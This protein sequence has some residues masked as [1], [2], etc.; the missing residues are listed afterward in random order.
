ML[1]LAVLAFS[2]LFV[3]NAWVS[4]DAKIT[5][6]SVEQ[7]HAGQ[8]PRWNPHERVQAF[9]HPLWF[10]LL[11]AARSLSAESFLNAVVLSWALGLTAFLFSLRLFRDPW[12]WLL[13]WALLLS[14]RAF[15]D[16]SSSG[17]E[18]PLVFAL[19]TC[20]LVLFAD[21]MVVFE[22][23]A[24]AGIL[25]A[26]ATVS[27]LL[28]CRHD[29]ALLVGPPFLAFL[30]PR[31]RAA[32]RRAIATVAIGALPFVA[33]TLF[34]TVYYGFP[35]PNT[36]YAKL[37]TGIPDSDLWRQGIA[38]VVNLARWDPLTLVM[39]V[40]AIIV[41]LRERSPGVWWGL[42]MLAYTG[43]I[44]RIGGD[45]M[46]G[47]FFTPVL[48]V[49]AFTLAA[50]FPLARYGGV[51]AAS[52]LLYTLVL[53]GSP[54]KVGPDY[55]AAYDYN[56]PV[57]AGITDEKG[58]YFKGS[59]LWGH[60]AGRDR[61]GPPIDE[62]VTVAGAVGATGLQAG[63]DHIV[64]DENA[65]CDPLLARLP[66]E[67][68]WRIGHFRRAVPRGYP[69]SLRAGRNLIVNP[70]VHSLY[71]DVR[72]VTQGPLWDADRWRAIARLNLRPPR[73]PCADPPC[74]ELALYVMPVSTYVPRFWR[75]TGSLDRVRADGPV[76]SVEGRVPFGDL[77]R[78][79]LHVAVPVAAQDS[80]VAPGPGPGTFVLDLRFAT[81][82][83]AERAAR[84]LCIAAESADSSSWA[85]L[86]SDR[87][88]CSRLLGR[89]SQGSR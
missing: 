42:G 51:L 1:L 79:K 58:Y 16:F 24:P 81:P 32:P 62:P 73:L 63:L 82:V 25:P 39:L 50:R 54:W 19:L 35:F 57:E 9:T 75:Q 48:L 3:R 80:R 28:L 10:L 11:A 67:H 6:R 34:A 20:L 76:V 31:V 29:L 52:L 23:S 40:S 8:G 68:P 56:T 22:A 74:R 89:G 46:A 5:F 13:A 30:V 86:A 53:P 59:S 38:Y 88:V 65:L 66:A 70:Y 45:F 27:L 49:A 18:N 33:W 71:D 55:R 17:L 83:E 61:P 15:V 44:V 41:A 87:P 78:Q 60:L 37:A 47:R 77:V 84:E 69:E 2:G 85:L 26:T 43:Y 4:D 7:L 36:A 12:R 64:V 21:R 72:Q 14:S